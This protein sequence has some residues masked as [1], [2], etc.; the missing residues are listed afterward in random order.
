MAL[1]GGATSV[2]GPMLGVVPLVLI[3]DYL[4]VTVPN[5]FSVVLGL[6]LLGIVF[7]IPNGLIGLLQTW[8]SRL[9]TQDLSQR[10]HALA[11]RI[12]NRAPGRTTLSGRP[13]KQDGSHGSPP[14]P[15]RTRQP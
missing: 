10:L 1:L 9:G 6:A 5:Y 13:A 12:G 15:D 4:S 3:S 7:F 2:W 8:R 11:D 14:P